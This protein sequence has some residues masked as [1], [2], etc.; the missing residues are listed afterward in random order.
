MFVKQESA[1]Y[2][3][4]HLVYLLWSRSF[5]FFPLFHYLKPFLA[6]FAE[7]NGAHTLSKH[8]QNE[9]ITIGIMTRR[10]GEYVCVCV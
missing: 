8:R 10:V 3:P 6:P 7:W 4:N 2:G 9:V 1:H 5:A